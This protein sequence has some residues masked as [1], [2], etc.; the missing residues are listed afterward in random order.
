MRYT[1]ER[2]RFAATFGNDNTACVANQQAL[3]GV[4][5]ERRAGARLAGGI[6]GL[7]CQGNSTSEL[8]GVSINDQRS[9]DEFTGTAILSYKPI[10][11]L[12]VYASFSRGY[13]AG[14]F[15]LDRSALKSPIVRRSPRTSGGAQALVRNLQFD[16][17]KVNAFEIGAKYATGPFSLSVAAFRQEFSN[18][19]LNTFDGTVFIVQNVNGCSVS[20]GGARP[21]PEQVHRRGRTTTPRRRRPAHVRRAT[22]ATACVSQGVE[23]EASL[24]PMRD[25]ARQAG[26]TYADTKYRDEPGRQQRRRA[27]QPGAAQ[28][29]GRQSVERARDRRH[30]RR[31]PGR[32]SSAAA[33]CAACSTSIRRMTGD[34]NTG[35]DL[36]PQKEQDGYALVNAR[37][38]IRGPD[39]TLGD[40]V[41][42]A[43][44]ASTRIMR[45]SR[46]TRRS[47]KA[48]LDRARS[49][50][51]SIRAAASSSRSSWPSRGPMA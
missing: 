8:N 1:N 28:A 51:R 16:P 37:V 3:T 47:R 50:I 43:E 20:L 45:R 41:L 48:A 7:S 27:A 17:E 30:R 12:L 23:L 6:I 19:Q 22:S 29:A 46:S 15:N 24:V 33:G 13:K 2:K 26:F 32:R 31:S 34:Y 11:D 5:G 14:G 9:E 21:R 39:E 18:F 38:G 40:R 10:D 42:G 25:F 35:S 49:P 4:P 44:H 36:F